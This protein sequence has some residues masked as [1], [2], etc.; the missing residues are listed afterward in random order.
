MQIS[1]S[2][3]AVV[4]FGLLVSIVAVVPF[5]FMG[6]PHP[7]GMWHLQMPWTYDM[8]LHYDQ[9]RDFSQ[10]LAAGEIYPRW[11]EDTNRGFGAPT[12]CFYPPGVYYLTALL[13]PFLRDWILVLLAACLLIT[14]AS[15]IATYVLARRFVSTFA[16]LV[17]AAVYLLLPYHLVD[18]YH[19]GSLAELLSFVWMPLILF[20]ADRL[21]TGPRSWPTLA[22]LSL[23]YGAFVWSHP[24]TA[25][26]FSLVCLPLVFLM[27]F[28]RRDWKGLLWVAAGV[29]L[30]LALS[31]AYLFPAAAEENLI[32]HEIVQQKFP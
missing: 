22:G 7:G 8:A 31:A 23:S 3:V 28:W 15:A 2:S 16:A 11:E 25:Y 14:T 13:Y 19:R 12:A 4:S 32:R 1:G 9:M 26:Q 29:V 24:P 20:F 6:Q 27:A 10:G 30:G 17:A 21:L 5:F 18:L